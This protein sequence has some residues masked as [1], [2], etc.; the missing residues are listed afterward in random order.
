MVTL[1]FFRQNILGIHESSSKALKIMMAT[2]VMAIV[3]LAWCGATLIAHGPVND[4]PFAPDLR[5]KVEY[6]SVPGSTE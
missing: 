3:M 2:T 4:I 6:A 1:Y 5:P